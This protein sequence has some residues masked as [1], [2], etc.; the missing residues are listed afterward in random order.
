[1]ATSLHMS[2]KACLEIVGYQ[3]VTYHPFQEVH[4]LYNC[5]NMFNY[6]YISIYL[7]SNEES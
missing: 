2:D 7:T 3:R 5:L 1:M 4:I 6:K